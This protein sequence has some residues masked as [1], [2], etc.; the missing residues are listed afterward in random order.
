MNILHLLIHQPVLLTN[1]YV[2]DASFGFR[3]STLNRMDKVPLL[4]GLIF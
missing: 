4:I 3:E 1:Y 2:S